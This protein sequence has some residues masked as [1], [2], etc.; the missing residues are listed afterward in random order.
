MPRI[1]LP[2]DEVRAIAHYL[3][4]VDRTRTANPPGGQQPLAAI[5]PV[6]MRK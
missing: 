5:Q 2:D 3:A 6:S 4:A 1:D